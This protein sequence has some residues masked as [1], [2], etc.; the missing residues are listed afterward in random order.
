MRC[1][2]A[3]LFLSSCAAQTL[4]PAS[5]ITKLAVDSSGNIYAAQGSTIT[6]LNQWTTTVPFAVQSLN[7]GSNLLAA[8]PGGIVQIDPASGKILASSSLQVPS[9]MTTQS[10]VVTAAGNIVLSGAS[11]SN[12]ATP[13]AL[14]IPN[15]PGL[16]M[17]LDST[18]KLL[19]AAAG[20]GGAITV[21]AAENIYVAGSAP[22]G[23]FP[24]T[25]NALQPAAGFNLCETTGGL[26]PF[27]FA[28]PQ[29]Y[30]AKV[31]PDGTK[32]IFA[33]Y[34][35]GA[36]GAYPGDIELGPDGSIYT[37]GSVQAT[38]YPV[39]A[40]ALF[41]KFPAKFNDTLCS[42]IVP[43]TSYAVSGF[44]SRLSADGSQLLYSTYLG[45][46][47]ADHPASVAVGKDGSMF[48]AGV[49]SSPDLPGLPV[50]IETCKPGNSVEITKQRDFLMQISPDGLS[51]AAAQLIGGTNPGAGIAC[52]TDAADTYYADVVSPGE[53][54]TINGFGVGPDV[55][56]VPGLANPTPQIGGVSVMFDGIPALLTA[57]GGTLVTASVPLAVAG[58]K[59]TTMTLLHNGQPFDSRTLSVTEI[60]PSVFFLPPNGK[61]CNLPPQVQFG[62]F[63]GGSPPP[64][65]LILNADGTINACD[66]PASA[67]SVLTFFMNGADSETLTVA[68]GELKVIGQSM[69]G[70]TSVSEVS[71]QLLKGL[72]NPFYFTISVGSTPGRDAVPVYVK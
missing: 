27:G 22:D 71:V 39:T 49:T 37:V 11:V 45:G 53:L 34:L 30:I 35:T 4:Q 14:N 63:L 28:C 43:S 32:M 66:N 58:Q 52:I 68:G 72:P 23:K 36:L 15:E 51:I 12:T 7:A 56:E 19:W 8:G 2:S 16:L 3:L 60:T 18:G 61:S 55:S 26:I 31:S 47:Q 69:D 57:A 41:P 42:C 17:K 54:I 25:P 21:D 6:K 38:D 13:G 59:Q 50:Q 46:S 24:T 1:A 33:T 65:P 62:M 64:A 67:G 20:I 40:G 44:L 10:V 29:Q 70:L 48:V 9:G 5:P